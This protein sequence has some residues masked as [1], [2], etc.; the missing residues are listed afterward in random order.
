MSKMYKHFKDVEGIPKIRNYGME[1]GFN[2]LIIDFIGSSLNEC[3]LKKKE[4]IK[5]IPSVIDILKRIHKLGIVHRDIKPENLLFKRETNSI[6]LIDFGLSKSFLQINNNH[7]EERNERKLIGTAKYSSLNVHNG[8]E[9]SRRDD[10]ES[11]CFTF[12]ELY[13]NYLPWENLK[14]T[15]YDN[16]IDLYKDIKK[17][18]EKSLRWMY[19]LPGEFLIL[20]LYSRNL[21]FDEEPNYEYLKNIFTNLLTI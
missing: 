7:I 19:N 4:I 18:K 3:N 21:K 6:Y 10:I 20:L 13:G 11:L 12:S 1:N 2:Y 14:Q 5:I 9:A 16:K 8:I 15:D 17:Y